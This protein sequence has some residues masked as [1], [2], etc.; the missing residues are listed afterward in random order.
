M[1]ELSSFPIDSIAA[2]VYLSTAGELLVD[3]PTYRLTLQGWIRDFEVEVDPSL[4]SFDGGAQVSVHG[5]RDIR[6]FMTMPRIQT[7]S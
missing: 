3:N 1:C 6:T 2:Y 5:V 4:S 7:T